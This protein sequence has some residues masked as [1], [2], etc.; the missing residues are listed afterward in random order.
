MTNTKDYDSVLDM[1]RDISV[2][3]KFVAEF[4]KI[5]TG[6]KPQKLH[7]LV[8]CLSTI[9]HEQNHKI[10]VM[11]K[12]K[13]KYKLLRKR[14]RGIANYPAKGHARRTDDGYPNEF[15]YDEFAYRRMVDSYREGIRGAIK[16]ADKEKE[17][18]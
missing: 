6:N 16:D 18:V 12:W 7:Q 14:L 5:L 11:S 3:P 8:L 13:T 1:V 17:V 2:D 15:T 10:K 9:V 4:E